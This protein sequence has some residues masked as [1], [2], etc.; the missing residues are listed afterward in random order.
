MDYD[1]DTKDY[2]VGCPTLDKFTPDLE[3]EIDNAGKALYRITFNDGR[4]QKND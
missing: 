2:I 1:C 4:L 3:P